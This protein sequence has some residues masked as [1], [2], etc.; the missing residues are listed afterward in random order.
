MANP[1]TGTSFMKLVEGQ[2]Y[3][4]RTLGRMGRNYTHYKICKVC[5]HREGFKRNEVGLESWMCACDCHK[6]EEIVIKPK[7][8][9]KEPKSKVD[10]PMDRLEL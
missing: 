8:E 5:G 3:T 10:N 6:K 7:S 9:P 2:E 4:I 1:A